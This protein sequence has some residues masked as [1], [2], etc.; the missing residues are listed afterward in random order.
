MKKMKKFDV[1][2]HTIVKI[3]M[4]KTKSYVAIKA[5][6]ICFK[7]KLLVFTHQKIKVI[8]PNF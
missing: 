7:L 1:N 6:L 4:F 8:Y 5:N 2:L 3:R